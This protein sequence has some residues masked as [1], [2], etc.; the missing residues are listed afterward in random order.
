MTTSGVPTGPGPLRTGSL[1]RRVTVIVVAVLAVVL[2]AILVTVNAVFVYETN[3]DIAAVLN[4]QK[5]TAVALAKR[6]VKP[7]VLLNQMDNANT[8]VGLQLVDGQT[9]G[10]VPDTDQPLPVD[11][12]MTTATLK[13]PG[14]LNN[15]TLW[16]QLNTAPIVRAQQELRRVL[17]LVGLIALG[18]TGAVL[19]VSVR[20]AL[21]PLAVITG[22]ARAI[23]G[24]SRGWRLSPTRTDTELGSTAAAFDDMLDAMEGAEHQARIAEAASRASE[25]RTRRFVADAA[26][27][28]R[29]PIA[30]VQA[31]AEAVLQQAPD[32]DQDERD[33]LHLLLVRESRRA[34]RL[35]NDLLDLARL[36]AG[37]DLTA[38][39]VDLRAL[40]DTQADRIRLLAPELDVR[41]EGPRLTVWADDARITQVVA[42]LLDNARHATNT[43]G[44]IGVWLRQVGTNACLLVTDDGHGVPPA[45]RERIF[46]RLVRLDVARERRFGGSGLGLPIARGFARAHGGDLTCEPPQPGTTGAVFRL[47]LPIRVDPAATTERLR[48][49]WIDRPDGPRGRRGPSEQARPQSAMAEPTT[50]R[51]E[52][53][54]VDGWPPHA[55]SD[56]SRS[57]DP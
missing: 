36:D 45:D 14:P 47:T 24:G 57:V 20:L 37:V 30:G 18:V 2:F 55:D 15:A 54:L 31:A 28:L 12:R 11:V 49:N 26:H 5:A 52:M 3:R 42:N 38:G 8:R 33:R 10:N 21:R 43:D 53:P 25:E 50:V 23:A 41:V 35:V 1:R 39:P 48:T 51:T 16:L 46:D 44:H 27:E 6:D 4:E 22:L 29:T 32:A 34:S 40:A 9:F 56:R 19:V 13:S 7:A 17:L